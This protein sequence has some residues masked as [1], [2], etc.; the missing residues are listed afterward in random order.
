MMELA[1]MVDMAVES[2]DD[3]RIQKLLIKQCI[4]F[5]LRSDLH[6]DTRMS[7]SQMWG[8]LRD[9]AK[10]KDLGPGKPKT[11]KDAVER[12]RDVLVAVG[13]EITLEAVHLAFHVKEAPDAEAQAEQAVPAGGPAQDVGAAGHAGATTPA[14]DLRPID[15]GPGDEPGRTTGQPDHDLPGPTEGREG[16]AGDPRTPPHPNAGTPWD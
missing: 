12:T 15:V 14:V 5:A 2:G 1:A 3:E 10:A 13:P 8:K 6:P 4:V 7:A 9:M 16:Q 11:R